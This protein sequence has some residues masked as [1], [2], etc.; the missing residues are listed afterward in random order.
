MIELSKAC[1][2]Q[3]DI[4]DAV[5]MPYY[6]SS[7]PRYFD[8]GKKFGK[9]KKK[10]ADTKKKP[11]KKKAVKKVIKKPPNLPIKSVQHDLFSDFLANDIS[12]VS[13]TVDLWERIPKYF[14]SPQEQK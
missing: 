11:A 3:L 14:L 9:G 1:V 10:M 7:D 6:D 5:L 12:E 8:K 4:K 13:N 2:K